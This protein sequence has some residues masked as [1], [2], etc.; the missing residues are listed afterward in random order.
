MD[1][2]D[3]LIEQLIKEKGGTKEK[4]LQLLD[5]IAYHESAGTNDTTLSQYGGGPGRG[6]YQF[7]T[8]KNAGGITAARRAKA[9]YKQLG[10]AIPE[11]L[12]N[13][14]KSDSLDVSSLDRGQQDVLFLSNMRKHP[15]A[16]FSKVMKGDQSIANFWA[17]N[18]WAGA[19]EDR[20]DRLASFNLSQ[21]TLNNTK[22]NDN[23]HSNTSSD[24]SIQNKKIVP[25]PKKE[26]T[27]DKTYINTPIIRD[28]RAEAINSYKPELYGAIV[29][30]NRK[31]TRDN[32]NGTDSS[33]LMAQS[34][35]RAF[36]MLYQNADDSWRQFEEDDWKEAQ[37]YAN[38]IN[39]LYTFD[40]VGEASKFAEGSWKTPGRQFNYGGNMGLSTY[41]DKNINIYGTGGSHESN[42]NGGIPQGIGSNGK[43]NTVEEGE[44]SYE[45]KT[46]KFIFSNRIRYE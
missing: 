40:T 46:G 34:D 6:V 24:L 12:Q 33:H 30:N 37:N 20:K 17:D 23:I 5:S 26:N 1:E 29:R 16:D 7:E 13:S 28:D 38:D 43:Q 36:P 25:Y 4:Y 18:H 27:I 21:E 15:K 19:K 44:A 32:N 10:K 2:R 31:G 3:K 42:P 9:Y 45:F 35:N 41:K 11:W 22:N 14:T 39:E 8:G